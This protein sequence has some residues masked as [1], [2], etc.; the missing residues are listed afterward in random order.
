VCADVL[1]F[2]PPLPAQESNGRAGKTPSLTVLDACAVFRPGRVVSRPKRE[3]DRGQGGTQRAARCIAVFVPSTASFVPSLPFHRCLPTPLLC[4]ASLPRPFSRP[5]VTF[6][7][8]NVLPMTESGEEPFHQNQEAAKR[9]KPAQKRKQPGTTAFSAASTVVVPP[10]PLS[11]S[12]STSASS[13]PYSSSSSLLSSNTLNNNTA[14]STSTGSPGFVYQQPT[15]LQHQRLPSQTLLPLDPNGYGF[16]EVSGTPSPYLSSLFFCMP[17]LL[18]KP[19]SQ[20]D[21]QESNRPIDSAW[22]QGGF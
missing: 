4:C 18:L 11:L 22:D 3:S 6:S 13:S 10:R 15:S 7:G 2:L 17:H 1:F 16:G 9:F 21:R 5:L 20:T 12:T 8:S 19:D 14:V